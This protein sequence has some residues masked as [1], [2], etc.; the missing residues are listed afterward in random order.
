MKAFRERVATIVV[1]VV[2]LLFVLLLRVVFR[3]FSA[4]VEKQRL[5]VESA[6]TRLVRH[7]KK[8]WPAYAILFPALASM[9]V[10][11][12]YPLLRGSVMSFQDYRLI[13]ASKMGGMRELQQRTLR[14]ALLAGD[15]EQRALRGAGARWGSPRRSF[16]P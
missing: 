4:D 16:W 5:A 14:D 8:T 10:W 7:W 15:V 6:R 13:G 12:Y 3:S 9:L 11:Q 1:S 2:A